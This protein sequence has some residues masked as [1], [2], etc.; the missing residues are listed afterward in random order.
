MQRTYI[1][2]TTPKHSKIPKQSPTPGEA[3]GRV[4]NDPMD[5]ILQGDGL[6]SLGGT[7]VATA[8]LNARSPRASAVVV[9]MC[10]CFKAK[11]IQKRKKIKVAWEVIFGGRKCF[12]MIGWVYRP[13]QRFRICIVTYS[14]STVWVKLENLSKTYTPSI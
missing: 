11:R 7:T 10:F 9:T 14:Y 1:K 2:Y 5:A 6:R 13:P 12:L 4:A 3:P 8:G